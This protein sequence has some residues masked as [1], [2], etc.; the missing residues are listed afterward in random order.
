[1]HLRRLLRRHPDMACRSIFQH[2][3]VHY[4]RA[5]IVQLCYAFR[6]SLFA[7]HTRCCVWC[8]GL[9]R[10]LL[11]LF[12]AYTL[13]LVVIIGQQ[14]GNPLQCIG[15]GVSELQSIATFTARDLYFLYVALLVF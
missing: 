15:A 5:A 4:M 2:L 3:L 6:T 11:L 12:S 10:K 7:L 14:L 8:L 9:F 13:F 1:M